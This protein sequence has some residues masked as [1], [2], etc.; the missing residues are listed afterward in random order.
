MI[1]IEAPVSKITLDRLHSLSAKELLYLM[2][3]RGSDS[4]KP[5]ETLAIP[6]RI[7]GAVKAMIDEQVVVASIILQ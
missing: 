2:W 6:Q 4:V 3:N 1:C 5:F 7:I